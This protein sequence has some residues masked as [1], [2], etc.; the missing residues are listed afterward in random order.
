MTSDRDHQL[1]AK[2]RGKNKIGDSAPRV[3]TPPHNGRCAAVEDGEA[4]PI[5]RVNSEQNFTRDTANKI[6][7][8]AHL[9]R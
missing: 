9:M 4:P 3:H 2:G 7:W 5:Y 8:K 1:E 6:A